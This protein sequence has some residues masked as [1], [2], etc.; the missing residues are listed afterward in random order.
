MLTMTETAEQVTAT[1]E[2]LPAGTP[3]IALTESAAGIENATAAGT[4]RLAFGVGD[5]RR[6]TGASEI[7]RAHEAC[8]LTAEMGMTGKPCPARK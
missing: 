4:F 6:D 2:K 3:A 5:F 7:P 8:S 1:A